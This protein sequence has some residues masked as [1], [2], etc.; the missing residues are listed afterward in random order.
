MTIIGLAEALPS[1]SSNRNVV[2][3]E[4]YERVPKVAFHNGH[5]Q[6]LVLFYL[7]RYVS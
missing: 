6:D 1:K 5:R 3:I 2:V 7:S 4:G